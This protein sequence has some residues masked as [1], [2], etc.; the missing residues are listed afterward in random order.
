MSDPQ[1]RP[2]ADARP[3]LVGLAYRILGSYSDAEDVVQDAWLRW[4]GA[5]QS[6]IENPNGWLTTVVT[7]LALDRL[8]RGQREQERYV[9]PWLP[10]P[11]VNRGDPASMVEM[12]DSLTT[13]YLLVLEE[14]SPEE[15]VAFLLVDVFGEPFRSV[16]EILD[17]TDEACRQLASRARKKLRR[18][19]E[20]THQLDASERAAAER[21]IAAL[22]TGDTDTALDCVADD[23]VLISDGGPN[24]RAA[25]RPVQGRDR[26]VRF[27]VNIAARRPP[28]LN[29][30]LATVGGFPGAVFYDGNEPLLTLSFE[31]I[32]GLFARVFIV[33]NPDKLRHLQRAG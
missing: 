14:L 21:F 3:R 26:V 22:A 12:A 33:S 8:R 4:S 2:F 28:N 16:A 30:S 6:V 10:E 13:A 25:R 32:D 11:L 17:R 20:A 27:L 29:W 19:N 23:A 24:R 18:G 31:A 9:G 7:R 1:V 15:R 5:D